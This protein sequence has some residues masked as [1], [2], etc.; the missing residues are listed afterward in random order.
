MAVAAWQRQ[1]LPR[2]PCSG[3]S[4]P[5]GTHRLCQ[6]VHI[7]THLNSPMR[8]VFSALQGSLLGRP[9]GKVLLFFIRPAGKAIIITFLFSA[10][11]RP[12]EVSLQHLIIIAGN[13][14]V[15]ASRKLQIKHPTSLRPRVLTNLGGLDGVPPWIAGTMPQPLRNAHSNM[16][17]LVSRCL[18]AICCL[19]NSDPLPSLALPRLNP[20]ILSCS[21]ETTTATTRATTTTTPLLEEAPAARCDP[22]PS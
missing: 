15:D 22:R 19:F 1:Q 20:S 5:A 6:R 9:A 17:R 3:H 14:K 21:D 8:R 7:T 10:V 4:E 12:Q 18:I 16:P 11:S 13:I 2:Q